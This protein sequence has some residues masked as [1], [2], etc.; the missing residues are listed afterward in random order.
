MTNHI[1][2]S[3][4]MPYFSLVLQLKQVPVAMMQPISELLL[5]SFIENLIFFFKNVLQARHFMVS[6]IWDYI[7]GGI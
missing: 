6:R 5:N 1:V 7:R 2:C 3:A 4:A